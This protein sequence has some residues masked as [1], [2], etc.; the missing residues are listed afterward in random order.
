MRTLL[1]AIVGLVVAAPGGASA[2]VC[3]ASPYEW[4]CVINNGLAPPNSENVIDD[5]THSDEWIFVRNV[6]CPP[7]WP[8]GAYA[9]DECASPGAP[10]VVELT[11]SGVVWYL[12]AYDSSTVT[13]NGGQV[14]ELGTWNSSILTI[15][16]GAVNGNLYADNSSTVT[17]VGGM[18]N[19]DL[20]AYASSNVT[21]SGGVV[22]QAMLAYDDSSIAIVGRDFEVDGVPVPYGDLT[23]Q[24]G[25]LTGTLAAGDSIDNLFCQG[26]Y[27]G[28]CTGTMTLVE[29]PSQYCADGTIAGTEECDDGNNVPGDGCDASCHIESGW[30]CVGEPSVCTRRLPPVPGLSSWSQ[31]ALVVG[32]IGAGMGSLRRV[33]TTGAAS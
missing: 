21:M 22:T 4:H 31:F 30:Q 7:G 16:A 25:T 10:T 6:G 15:S 5:G 33:R 3:G 1:I 18:V 11:G 2:A 24:T 32:L 20:Y 17:V 14:E 23:A 19:G 12:D 13:M 27:M 29:S 28:V 8:G 9:F 26:G